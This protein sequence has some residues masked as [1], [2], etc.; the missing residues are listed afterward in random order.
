M[1]RASERRAG[2]GGGAVRRGRVSHLHQRERHALRGGDRLPV[3][4]QVIEPGSGGGCVPVV[5]HQ[6][7]DGHP[8]IPRN[9]HPV[10]RRQPLLRG[11]RDR[12]SE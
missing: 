3:V 12:V 1:A 6:H 11:R 7:P 5:V 2:R 4:S 10:Q 9:Q 8:A